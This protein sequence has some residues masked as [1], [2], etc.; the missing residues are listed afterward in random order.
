[1]AFGRFH[2]IPVEVPGAV[3]RLAVLDG[4]PP[5]NTDAMRAWI[6]DAANSVAA[7]NGRFPVP[8]PQVLVMPG[9]RAQRADAV[10]LRSARWSGGGSFLRQ[11]GAE[12]LRD[13]VEDWTAPHELSHLL[14]PYVSSS[15]A[16]LSEGMATYYQNVVRARSG[17]ITRGGRVAAHARGIQARSGD[18]RQ[19]L[20][21]GAGDG[22]H[23]PRRRLHARCTGPEPPC[24]CWVMSNCVAVRT[25]VNRS[26]RYWRRSRMLLDPD[27]EWTAR[28]VF[29]KF[30]ELSQTDVFNTLFDTYVQS[31]SFPISARPT[32]SSV[33]RRWAASSR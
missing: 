18:N 23:V 7:I 27:P 3:L 29:E 26:T 14:L 32:P 11:T 1:M 25:I 31:T 4:S 2:E 8:S 12:P 20:D 6:Q 17:A 33:S 21:L 19:G 24:C 13:Y 5:A 10:G 9:A 16:W 28:K 15:D 30:D 22:A